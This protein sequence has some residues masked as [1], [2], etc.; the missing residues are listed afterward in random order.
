MKET[1]KRLGDLMVSA[2]FITEDQLQTA[3][4]EKESSQKLGDFLVQQGIITELQLVEVLEFQLGISHVSL[5]RY[6]FDETLTNVIPKEMAKRHLVYPLKKQGDKLYVAMNDPLDYFVIN[7]LRMLTG[8]QI[9]PLFALKDDLI[10]TINRFLD[11]ESFDEWSSEMDAMLKTGTL[12]E[13]DSPAVKIVNQILQHAIHQ[14][15]SDIHIDPYEAKVVVRYRVDGKLHTERTF[16]KHMQGMV[17]ARIKIMSQMDITESRIPQDGRL[18]YTVDYHEVDVRISTLPTIFGEK[19]VLRLLDLGNALNDITKLGFHSINM[20]R[21]Q[22]LVLKPHGIILITGPTG[23]GKSSTLYSALNQLNTEAVNIITVEDPVEYQID[24]ISQIQ[25]NPQTGMNFA[26]GLR[27]ILRQDPNIIMIGEIRDRETAEIA[28]RASLTGHLVLSTLHTNDSIGTVTR[29]ID[30]GVEPFMVATALNGI[31]SQRLVRRVCRDCSG[32]VEPTNREIEIFAENGIEIDRIF[33]GKGCSTCNHT[34]YK[35]RVAIH[36]LLMIDDE[37]RRE[38][39][40]GADFTILK[41]LA[42]NKKTIFLLEDGL[43]KVKQG[44]TTTEEILRVTIS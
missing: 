11:T 28:I 7:D 43:L 30:M 6:P 36:E 34:G 3:L 23:S 8:F 15:A 24:G 14:K 31:V 35:G 22:Q 17:N 9:V 33:R 2:G 27:S 32:A 13:D 44:V 1:R 38:I 29:L 37:L 41:N 4:K 12:N 18:K 42:F 26:T 25:V 19:I 21:F 40:N 10:R 16:P 20:E 39:A 5:Y